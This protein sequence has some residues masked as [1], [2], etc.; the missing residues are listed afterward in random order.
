MLGT[1]F[2]K[3]AQQVTESAIQTK[4]VSEWVHA[5]KSIGQ[6]ILNAASQGNWSCRYM[7][8]HKANGDKAEKLLVATGFK[9]TQVSNRTHQY[10]STFHGNQHDIRTTQAVLRHSR[11]QELLGKE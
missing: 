1:N 4:I 2:L 8:T 9:V 7:M 10:I 11:N 3:R 5:Q 6:A